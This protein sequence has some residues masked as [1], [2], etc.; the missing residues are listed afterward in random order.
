M[1]RTILPAFALAAIAAPA[2]A[3]TV[4]FVE[5]FAAGD[6]NWRNAASA[7]VDFSASGSF[8]GSSFISTSFNFVNNAANE[9]L[10]IFRGQS[11]FG[12]SGGAFV[13]DWISDGVAEFS[14]YIRHDGPSP[15]NFFA[16][17]AGPFNFPGGVAVDFAPVA[18]GV[19]T[20]LSFTIDASNPQFVSFEGTDFNT[21]FSNIG[22]V[23]IG[24]RVPAA[25]AGL[26]QPITFALDNVAITGG[27]IPTP[28]AATLFAVAG[29][30]AAR[31]R[32]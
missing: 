26:D 12:S 29:L 32:R 4:P 9:D 13:G 25:F 3:A 2:F 30:A 10:V 21:V 11:A 17:F 28:G 5:T 14:F 15:A 24:V 19:W 8:D 16:R 7:A 23:Q 20:Q 31:R 18:A 1:I 27:V 6:A 22:N